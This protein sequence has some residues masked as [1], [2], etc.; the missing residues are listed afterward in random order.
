VRG[1]LSRPAE[2]DTARKSAAHPLD[3]AIEG[4]AAALVWRKRLAPHSQCRMRI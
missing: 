3:L 1:E 2:P 4:E